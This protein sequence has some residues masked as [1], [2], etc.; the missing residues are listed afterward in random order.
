MMRRRWPLPVLVLVLVGCTDGSDGGSA[1]STAPAATTTTAAAVT[2][3][4]VGTSTTTAS[5][6]PGGLVGVWSSSEGDATLAYRFTAD[7]GYR[8]AGL[9]T[10]PRAT[11]VFEFRVVERGTVT[12]RGD[13]MT[14][15][16]TAGTTTRK[17]PDDPGGDY[18]R[19]ITTEPRR[20]TWRLDTSGG[21][22]VLYLKDTDGVEV[23]YDRE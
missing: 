18:E 15:R 16:P 22:D 1:A 21:R 20:F 23:S 8:H 19:P 5:G 12:V 11:G 17:D 13:R 10:Q 14:L 4:T 6:L 2:A 7:G 9:L 3:T